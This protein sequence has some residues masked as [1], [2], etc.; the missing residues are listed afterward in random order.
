MQEES[1]KTKPKRRIPRIPKRIS[2]EESEKRKNPK[3]GEVEEDLRVSSA[4]R[5][6]AIRQRIHELVIANLKPSFSFVLSIIGIAIFIR[7]VHLILPACCGWMDESQLNFID[8]VL[9][10]IFGGVVVKYF[11]DI[12]P[13][14]S[15]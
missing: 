1:K 3:I 10:F 7:F 14:K 15:S 13:K 5:K 4:K 2:E 11:S 8:K 6:E 12:F 9:A